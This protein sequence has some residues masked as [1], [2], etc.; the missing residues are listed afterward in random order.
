MPA[1]TDATAVSTSEVTEDVPG[2]AGADVS[3]EGATVEAEREAEAFFAGGGGKLGIRPVRALGGGSGGVPW[4]A[5]KAGGAGGLEAGSLGADKVSSG[6]SDSS[7][8]DFFFTGGMGGVSEPVLGRGGGKGGATG[9]GEAWA[10]GVSCA[11]PTKMGA[12][13]PLGGGAKGGAT[14]GRVATGGCGGTTA[15]DPPGVVMSEPDFVFGGGKGGATGAVFRE[16]TI[17]VDLESLDGIASG[18]VTIGVEGIAG[19]SPERREA[20][21]CLIWTGPVDRVGGGG[22]MGG[23]PEETG[24]VT[25]FEEKKPPGLGSSPE[26]EEESGGWGTR[27][28]GVRVAGGEMVTGGGLTGTGG[29][30]MAESDWVLCSAG[31]L[32]SWG[33]GSKRSSSAREAVSSLE[34]KTFALGFAMTTRG[35]APNFPDGVE[36]GN[37]GVALR[38]VGEP[39]D[40]DPPS[41]VG[42]K[43]GIVFAAGPAPVRGGAAGGR[44]GGGV[45]GTASGL[46]GSVVA[47]ETGGRGVIG[48]GGGFS[49]RGGRLIRKVSRFGTS[50]SELSGVGE[51]AES[52]ITIAFYSYFGKCS[53]AK[54]AIDI[55]FVLSF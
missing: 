8:P 32:A 7:D 29:C 22:I 33:I 51:S 1:A 27:G 41:A 9:A 53:M 18:C 50:D 48:A 2:W 36:R 43:R 35:G 37:S 12:D 5:A 20:V 46:I 24:S 45:G 14:G 54:F 38:S 49:G 47:A 55:S 28:E 44:S 13:L 40:E 30:G 42:G 25:F 16:G 39:V 34:M 6:K 21:G 52:A 31:G 11:P 19:I 15:E 4:G 3:C 26:D 23:A 10:G 17:G